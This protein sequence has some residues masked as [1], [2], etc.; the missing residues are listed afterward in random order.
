MR[1]RCRGHTGSRGTASPH[2]HG[3][4]IAATPNPVL[5]GESV[6][7]YG[8]LNGP[9]NAAQTVRLYH[10][11]NPQTSF[12]VAGMATTDSHG[13][14]EFP[15]GDGVVLSDRSWLVR[16][17]NGTH[18]RTLREGVAALVSLNSSTVTAN[19]GQLVVLSG[20][21]SPPHP[22]GP[23]K[24]QEQNGLSG[25]GWATI[26]ATSTDAS[27]NFSVPRRF[28]LPGLYTLRADFP[29]DPRNLEGDSDSLTVT[30]AQQQD[31]S[32]TIGSSAPVIPPG[33]PVTVSGVL[34]EPG[35]TVTVETSV[36]VTL[37]GKQAG[38][39]L[40]AL[41]IAVTGPDGSYSFSQSPVRNETYRVA[42]TKPHRVTANLYE[43]AQDVVT[44][45]ASST[46]GMVGGTVSL[47][48]TVT[49]DHTG[50]V[51]HL[52]CL[53]NDGYWHNVATG[54]VANGSTYSFTYTFGETGDIQLRV[55]IYGGPENV[56]GAAPPVMI[57]VS[58][59]VPVGS[60]PLAS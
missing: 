7:V 22:S 5:V 44:M 12:S 39:T 57:A 45:S 55:Q 20:H 58:G 26:A 6:L 37:Y 1:V 36:Q 52:Q 15:R 28:A 60:L 50:H 25:N 18:S 59:V 14:Y 31:P 53:G 16:G 8:Q 4:T 42:T 24:L 19:T 38:G 30:V 13:F 9:D 2:N 32:F 17:P 48:G 33:Q 11:V 56:G 27:S 41:A 3:M 35:S 34:Y 10:R 47:S 29:G 49:P 40:R 51:V 21:V 43:G 54:V 23:V 46:T